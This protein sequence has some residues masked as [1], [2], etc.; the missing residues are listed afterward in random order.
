ET[1]RSYASSLQNL[2]EKIT[3]MILASLGLDVK[4]FYSSDFEN[5]PFVLRIN[6]YSSREKS[7]GEEALPCHADLGCL[8]LLYQDDEG[9][10][11]I[12]AKEGK[13]FSVKPLPHSF[14]IN[15]GDALKAWSNG[16]C[17]SAEH[18]VVYTGWK[19]RMSI[20]MFSVFPDKKEIWAPA[21]LVDQENPRRYKPFI[22]SELVHEVLTN[23]E[24]REIATALERFAGL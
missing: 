21:E 18:R 5:C 12:R 2:A 20:A 6:G 22:Y 4:A 9:G 14:V 17:R 19:N 16:R 8:T 24:N 23:K 15:V 1:I 11:E 10:L 3:K 13:W 7:I